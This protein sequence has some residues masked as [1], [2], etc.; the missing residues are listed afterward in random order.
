[1]EDFQIILMEPQKGTREEREE[2]EL[3]SI[4]E[5]K[6]KLNTSGISIIILITWL[7][8]MGS[9]KA[10]SRCKRKEWMKLWLLEIPG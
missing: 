8:L 10:S 1:M 2:E 4:P 6:L 9:G 3:S 7:K 5:V